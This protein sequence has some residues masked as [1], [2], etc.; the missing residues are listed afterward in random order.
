MRKGLLIITVSI[1]SLISC[2]IYPASA[3][4]IDFTQ[5]T[6]SGGLVPAGNFSVQTAN[7]AI[8]PNSFSNPY[9]YSLYSN[10]VG[11]YT[12][13]QTSTGN[14]DSLHNVSLVAGANV[15]DTFPSNYINPNGAL[16]SEPFVDVETNFTGI[17]KGTG[18]IISLPITITNNP[19]PNSG[20]PW[21]AYITD[22]ATNTTVLTIHPD[23][24]ATTGT[25][26]Y[27]DSFQS[28]VGHTYALTFS[29]AANDGNLNPGIFVSNQDTISLQMGTPTI[30][31]TPEPSSWLLFGTGVLSM[32][33]MGFRKPNPLANKA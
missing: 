11:S 24:F 27:N 6:F 23:S 31:S 15:V 14:I 12:Y 26:F 20:N 8:Y 25:S 32:G 22:Q 16:V 21:L 9:T 29:I 18:G 28:Y 19:S 2:Y 17:F 13:S 7:P 10:N 1:L 4:M 5:Y 30:S 33:F 3:T